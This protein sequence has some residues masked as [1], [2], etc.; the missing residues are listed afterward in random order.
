MSDISK[1]DLLLFKYYVVQ[2]ALSY[3]GKFLGSA[4]EDNNTCVIILEE[5]ISNYSGLTL[6]VTGYNKVPI[7]YSVIVGNSCPESALGDIN[8][9]SNINIQDIVLLVSIVL[10]T[11]SP[12]E[13]QAEFGDMNSDGTFNV[14]DIVSLVGIILG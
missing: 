13:C 8:G 12:D 1:N 9:D 10:G 11:V 14:L 4:Y 6:T 5:D 2:N 7:I 3:N